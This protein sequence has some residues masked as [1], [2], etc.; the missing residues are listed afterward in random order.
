MSNSITNIRGRDADLWLLDEAAIDRLDGIAHPER[1]LSADELERFARLRRDSVRRRFLGGRMLCRHA[2]SA[3]ADVAPADWRFTYG[4]YGRPEI[5]SN[6]W[7]LLF[8]VSHTEGLLAC[9][10]ARE[11]LCGVDVELTPARPAA[12]AL[13]DKHFAVA[14]QAALRSLVPE[15]RAARFVDYW[16]LKESYTKALGTGLSRRLSTFAFD[17]RGDPIAVHDAERDPE[18]AR[19]WRFELL[20]VGRRHACAVA[21]R[22]DEPRA[23]RAHVR[24]VD[25]ATAMA[26]GRRPSC[27]RRHAEQRLPRRSSGHA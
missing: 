22:G 12:V 7:G 17:L 11:S 15:L 18:E 14:E 6:P 8:N 24:T 16:V 21:I 27:V 26:A 9:V 13:A 23:A 1:L 19:R 3:Y 10:V 4:A 20:R 25:F 5:E 2:L